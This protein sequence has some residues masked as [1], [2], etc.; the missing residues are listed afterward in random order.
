MDFEKSKATSNPLTQKFTTS[1]Q[2]SPEACRCNRKISADL[3]HGAAEAHAGRNGHDADKTARGCS[4]GV[5]KK[6]YA[7]RALR[8]S[9]LRRLAYSRR[10]NTA[11]YAMTAASRRL[12][13]N[14]PDAGATRMGIFHRQQITTAPWQ[15]DSPFGKEGRS[16][17]PYA[18]RASSHASWLPHASLA[19]DIDFAGERAERPFS[20]REASKPLL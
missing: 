16:G 19:L 6:R 10:S 3:H 4:I 20:Y 8:A 7:S 18:T 9:P 12:G 15:T 11:I 13:R 1:S 14:G 17:P 5:K 2:A